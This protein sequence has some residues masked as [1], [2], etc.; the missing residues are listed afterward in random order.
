MEKNIQFA[1][2]VMLIDA[3]YLGRVVRDM[4]RHYTTVVG[5][6]L[7][8]AD[9]ALL[10]ECLALDGGM[11]FGENEIQV[12]LFHDSAERQ[13]ST[14]IPSDY[15]K[16]LHGKAFESRLGE[17]SLYAFQPADMA[18]CETLFTEALSLALNAKETVRLLI[19]PDETGY[20]KE[21]L[22]LLDA[23]KVHKDISVFG[24]NPPSG[25]GG[26]AF[27][28]LGFSVLQALGIHADELR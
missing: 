22:S 15:E 25:Q 11:Q 13:I 24:M 17:F 20:G 9:L 28:L 23:E 21:V 12:L 7:P 1:P 8:K 4:H 6:D 3:S 14:C 18:S 26:Y 16:E 5:R 2:N 10:L 27:D 19:V